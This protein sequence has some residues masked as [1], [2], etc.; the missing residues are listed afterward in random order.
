MHPTLFLPILAALVLVL[1]LTAT[2]VSAD[3][4]TP[5]SRAYRVFDPVKKCAPTSCTTNADCAGVSGCGVC[6]GGMCAV[7]AGRY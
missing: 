4:T 1:V 3:S 2:S 7:A 5:V 6:T